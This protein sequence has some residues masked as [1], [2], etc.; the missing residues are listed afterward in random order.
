MSLRL[1]RLSPIFQTIREV[2][3]IGRKPRTKYDMRLGRKLP[4]D[5]MIVRQKPDQTFFI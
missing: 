2:P 5:F 1:N 4:I 3:G